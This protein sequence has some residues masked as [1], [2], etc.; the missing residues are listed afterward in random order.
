MYFWESAEVHRVPQRAAHYT[1][2][3]RSVNTFFEVLFSRT[4]KGAGKGP[5][6]AAASTGRLLGKA[7]I[8]RGKRLFRY[9]RASRAD[10]PCRRLHDRS[11]R[12]PAVLRVGIPQIHRGAA[13]GPGGRRRRRSERPSQR[14]RNQAS[15][16]V[17]RQS[18]YSCWLIRTL[19]KR[20]RLS[21]CGMSRYPKRSSSWVIAS[22]APA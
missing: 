8:S 17:A 22:V 20:S 21:F 6:K 14:C 13:P 10:T 16:L 2:Q 1:A 12:V 15:S 3:S 19:R 5:E 11:L 9:L 7:T 18:L 4:R